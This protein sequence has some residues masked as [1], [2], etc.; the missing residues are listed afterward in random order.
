[1]SFK[2]AGFNFPFLLFVQGRGSTALCPPP[3]PGLC[4]GPEPWLCPGGQD[5]AGVW[6]QD[7]D[8]QLSPEGPCALLPS[9]KLGC[10]SS[11]VSSL[12][13]PSPLLHPA[14]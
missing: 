6:L 12:R 1:M 4:S 13:F 9:A 3:I 8:G 2:Q 14:A 7:Q 10:G 11:S 5:R